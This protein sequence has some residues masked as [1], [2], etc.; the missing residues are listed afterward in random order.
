MTH[1]PQGAA[2]ISLFLPLTPTPGVSALR[3]ALARRDRVT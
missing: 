2:L 3:G 1:T